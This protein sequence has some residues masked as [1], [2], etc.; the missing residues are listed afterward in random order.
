MTRSPDAAGGDVAPAS[1]RASCATRSGRV[2]KV[3]AR[4]SDET[5][6]ADRHARSGAPEPEDPDAP[7]DNKLYKL[8]DREAETLG[9]TDWR[10]SRYFT[11]GKHGHI[12]RSRDKE[13]GVRMYAAGLRKKKVWIGGY[14]LPAVS[15][16]F[17]APFALHFFEADI[18]EHLGWPALYRK[19][20]TALNDDPDD[21][22]HRIVA[23]IADKA[24][25]NRTFIGH[26]TENGVAT[27]TPERGLP[28]GKV[29]KDLRDPDGR[30]DEHGPRCQYC[31]G[32]AAPPSGP[33]EG[34]AL[35]GSGDPRIA[36]RCAI[37]W[38]PECRAKMQTISTR[39]EYRA[40]L[41]IGRRERLFYDLLASHSHFEGVFDSWRDRYAVSGT[42]NAT[43]SK[44]RLSIK[45]Q[46]LRAAAALLAEWFR[47]CLRQGYIGNHA[48]LNTTKPVKRTRGAKLLVKLTAYR[49]K[50]GL[51]LPIGPMA[52][53]LPF[54]TAPAAAP[55]D[56][57]GPPPP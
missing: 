28:G 34:F 14:F 49:R 48:K 47:I 24:F 7:P 41:P 5:I 33:G 43:R 26:N 16:Y 32:P 51:D 20:M 55:P 45:A 8:S 19:A 52:A 37:G 39:R 22:Q 30:F 53:T 35:T 44:R 3:I 40:L 18:Q 10:R 13:V 54:R 17:W 27:I 36:Y 2:A 57:P 56:P 21:P 38:L 50:H 23:V 25:T 9:L 12:M 42:S 6:N 1:V 11:Y 15:D 31:G 46:R 29:W 4:A